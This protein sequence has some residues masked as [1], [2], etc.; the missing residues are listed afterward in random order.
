MITIEIEQS[1][2]EAINNTKN[3]AKKIKSYNFRGT[4][5]LKANIGWV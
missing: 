2:K 4:I 1:R 5:F 3:E